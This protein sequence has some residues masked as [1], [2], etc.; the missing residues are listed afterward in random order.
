MRILFK[1]ESDILNKHKQIS[2]EEFKNPLPRYRGVPF[3][4][5]NCKVTED[6]IEKDINAFSEMGFGGANL[7]SRIGLKTPYLSDEFMNLAVKSVEKLKD[8][9]MY[10]WLYDEDRWPSGTAGGLNAN[11]ENRSRC[12][13]FTKENKNDICKNKKEFEEEQKKGN[14]PDFYYLASYEINLDDSILTE[15]KRFDKY[16]ESTQIENVWHAYLMIQREDIWYSGFGYVDTLSHR[17]IQEFIKSTYDRYADFLQDEFGKSVPAIF[18]DEPQFA[19]KEALPEAES[20]KDI[21]LSYTD[22]MD[23]GFENEYGK[24]LLD[25]LPIL[26]WENSIEDGML[27]RHRYHEYITE[28]FSSA[29]FG[30]I[31]KWCETHGIALTGH[32][33]DEP[34]LLTQTRAVGE[35]MRC[36]RN[37][38]I[39]GI[40]ILFDSHE[41][42]T[43][44]QAQSISR[45]D[46]RDGVTSEL[47]GVTNWD[48]TLRG[49]KMQ[50]DWQ[51]ALG[52]TH[53]VPSL[54]LMRMGGV[55]KR[56]YPASLSHQCPW[57][58]KYKIIE[59]YFARVNTVLSAGKPVVKIAVIHPIE[60]YWLHW[61]PQR[62]TELD[63][64][65]L[66]EH[67]EDL[68]KWLLY[69]LLDFDFVSESQLPKQFS[70]IENGFGVGEMKYDVVLV[71][72]LHTIR[73]T[74]MELL[75]KFQQNGGRVVFL[76]RTPQFVDARENSECEVLAKQC[77]QIPFSKSFVCNL[78]ESVRD[79]DI[80]NP[81]NGKR[82]DDVLY[83][84]RVVG[85]ERYL[86]LCNTKREES[87]HFFDI[88]NEDSP[89]KINRIVIKGIFT[90]EE[91]SP[92]NGEITDICYWHKDSYT[93][94]EKRV[95]NG[96]SFIFKLKESTEQTKE[97]FS[98]KENKI[99]QDITLKPISYTLHEPNVLLLDMAEY[100]LDGEEYAEKEEV[101]RLHKKVNERCG[102]T[103]SMLQP[104]ALPDDTSSDHKLKLRFSFNSEIE[105]VPV[106][107]A[108]EKADIC[109]IE[110]NGKKV[111][112]APSGYYIDEDIETIEIGKI[113]LG[114]N[115]IEVEI[116]F[117]SQSVIEAAYLLGDFGVKV[118]G[119]K[120]TIIKP[121]TNLEFADI[122]NQGLPFYS[123]TLTYHCKVN[124]IKGKYRLKAWLFNAP[125]IEVLVDKNK[126]ADIFTA[127]YYAELGE[128]SEGEHDIEVTV[129]G[130]RYNTLGQ[131][132]NTN[133]GYA[134]YGEQS[135]Q[136]TGFNWSDEYR[137]KPFGIMSAPVLQKYKE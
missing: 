12:I 74:T 88:S 135:W 55:N 64:S 46:G 43:A 2:K 104:W 38:H 58:K 103:R 60:S 51:A 79:I 75:E 15:Y 86:F 31:Y 96:Q 5:W 126:S 20:E 112:D 72:G 78:L 26:V 53:R 41:Y 94:I 83:Q 122:V 115:E 133:S 105:N 69:S 40:D 36:Y 9:N 99:I 59:D 52:V 22:D 33:L 67:F 130:N 23:E 85:D 128:L 63:R 127:P 39:P 81:E 50:G 10:C 16:V 110:F 19:Y 21:H 73:S 45:Q 119:K 136:T 70:G 56:D 116:P 89:N 4:S 32:S 87:Q 8:K 48:F 24:K 62:Q 92:L 118:A 91:M 132:H 121:E 14:K 98:L 11:E 84:M 95:Y 68:T 49:H 66:E 111:S 102:Y 7:H 34:T 1:R 77:E 137:F 35:A 114:L 25:I 101:L 18:T 117:N 124:I 47:Y 134:W 106:K 93:F 90:V 6:K 57:Y 109:V 80:Y 65:E 27:W 29:F 61:G 17:V 13:L 76:G 100:S 120:L 97:V 30:E 44:K 37:M 108:I 129:Y 54:A 71:P 42:N 123:G 3:W 125:V 107:L 28:R 131:L 82:I 113:A